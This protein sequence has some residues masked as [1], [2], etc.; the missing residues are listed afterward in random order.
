MTAIIAPLRKGEIVKATRA[1]NWVSITLNLPI[2]INVNRPSF[3]KRLAACVDIL[4]KGYHDTSKQDVTLV[5]HYDQASELNDILIERIYYT[6]EGVYRGEQYT[7]RDQ[8]PN[9]SS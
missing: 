8:G 4:V 9:T 2:S 1:G 3:L 7:Y 6:D 5:M